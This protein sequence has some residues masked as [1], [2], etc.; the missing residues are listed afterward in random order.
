L[1]G[2]ALDGE[3]VAQALFEQVGAVE[4]RVGVRD[5]RELVVL[6]VGEVLGV[7]QSA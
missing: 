4:P 7:L 1:A 5:P 6:L 2:L 3:Y